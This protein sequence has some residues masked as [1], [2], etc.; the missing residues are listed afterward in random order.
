MLEASFADGHSFAHVDALVSDCLHHMMLSTSFSV[1]ACYKSN[2]VQGLN[3]HH[4]Q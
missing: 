1:L 2:C 4:M 3:G